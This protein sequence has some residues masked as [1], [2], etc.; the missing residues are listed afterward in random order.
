MQFTGKQQYIIMY[1][2]STSFPIVYLYNPLRI[3]LSW[4]NIRFIKYQ[5]LIIISLNKLKRTQLSY[6]NALI[7]Y[8]SVI[9]II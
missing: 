2:F 4:E 6:N 9:I 7:Y 8:S 3:I 5:H 1:Y